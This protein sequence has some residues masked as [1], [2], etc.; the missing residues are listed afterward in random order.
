MF[1]GGDLTT[2]RDTIS[3]IVE[4]D[5]YLRLVDQRLASGKMHESVR[6][7]LEK[8]KNPIFG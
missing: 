4:L 2:D 6:L 3:K 5:E 1:Y 7:A 8:A